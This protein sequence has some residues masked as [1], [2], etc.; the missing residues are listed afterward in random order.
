MPIESPSG[1]RLWRTYTDIYSVELS[2]ATPFLPLL[3]IGAHLHGHP[4][5]SGKSEVKLLPKVYNVYSLLVQV[6]R[7]CLKDDRVEGNGRNSTM[8]PQTYVTVHSYICSVIVS[9]QSQHLQ[10]VGY[11]D[12]IVATRWWLWL[13]FCWWWVFVVVWNNGMNTIL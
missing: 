7:H 2:I 3:M 13:I 6:A 8:R 9:S 12:R 5:H 10:E 11:R 4:I 1:L